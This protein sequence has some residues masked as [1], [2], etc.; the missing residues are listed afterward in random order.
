MAASPFSHGRTQSPAVNR[1]GRQ[2]RFGDGALTLHPALPEPLAL[3]LGNPQCH[4]DPKGT[5]IPRGGTVCS[6]SFP[7]PRRS[8]PGPP[9]S[10]PGS[11]T[12]WSASSPRGR[13]E[14]MGRVT[15]PR[16]I[17][18]TWGHTSITHPSFQGRTPVDFPFYF[19][20]SVYSL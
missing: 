8:D 10:Q 1:K 18:T 17:Q 11:A 16:G 5:W 20:S 13:A 3:P 7:L 15:W 4:L 6:R 9:G 2:V 14:F 19:K 12:W